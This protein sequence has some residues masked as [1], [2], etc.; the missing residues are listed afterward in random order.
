MDQRIGQRPGGVDVAVL[1]VIIGM[2]ALF[3]AAGFGKLTESAPRPA[4]GGAPGAAQATGGEGSSAKGGAGDGRA[5]APGRVGA[6][7]RVV[8]QGDLLV[9]LSGYLTPADVEPV[10]SLLIADLAREGFHVEGAVADARWHRL[11]LDGDG[12]DEYLVFLDLTDGPS[13][14]GPGRYLIV[15]RQTDGIWRAGPV[16][17][18]AKASEGAAPADRIT[19]Q[20]RVLSLVKLVFGQADPPC[21]PSLSREL[22][23]DI[24]ADATPVMRASGPGGDGEGRW[25]G[26]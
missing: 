18:V 24:A 25:P 4:P 11:D 20:D 22:A 14:D 15:Y 5:G 19:L 8:R 1:M 3:G 23:F 17:T 6:V 16:Q 2:L 9:S 7:P 12:G 26:R 10:H 21:C 13:G